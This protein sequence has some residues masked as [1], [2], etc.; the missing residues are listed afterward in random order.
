[1]GKQDVVHRSSTTQNLVV[2]RIVSEM[3]LIK[4]QFA[5]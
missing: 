3:G 2:A 5:T 1:M 4:L